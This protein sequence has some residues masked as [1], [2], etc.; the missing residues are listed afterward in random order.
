MIK[1]YFTIIFALLALLPQA[2]N[3]SS[4]A[5]VCTATGNCGFCD[6]VATAVTLGKWLIT[7]ASGLALLIIVWAAFGLVTSAGNQEKTGAAKKQIVGALLGIVIVFLAF[8]LVVMII[9]IFATPDKLTSY[10]AATEKDE[11]EEALKHAS[12]SRFLGG[13]AWWTICN[14][15]DL[16]DQGGKE[17]DKKKPTADC[18]YWGDGTAC[19]NEF[20]KICISGECTDSHSAKSGKYKGK[21]VKNPCDFLKAYDI[22]Y[23]AG[24]IG[25]TEYTDYACRAREDCFTAISIEEGLCKYDEKQAKEQQ[26]VCCAGK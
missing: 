7:G 23:Q 25:T 9:G 3:A 17:T 13:A 24:K 2:A 5:R 4:L 12:L 18:K 11:G 22:T 19:N 8:Q 20:T 14:E 10:K 15:Q 16:R 1:K 6:I 21:P 26:N